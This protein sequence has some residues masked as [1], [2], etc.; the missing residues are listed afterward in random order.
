MTSSVS[1]IPAA[2]IAAAALALPA[3]AGAAQT[4]GSSLDTARGPATSLACQGCSFALDHIDGLQTWT[5]PGVITSFTAKLGAGDLA[6]LRV[7]TREGANRFV[8]V[9]TA[10]AVSG[11]GEVATYPASLRVPANAT[12]GLALQGRLA[13]I[14]GTGRVGIAATSGDGTAA[15]ST[16]ED[17]EPLLSAK[18]ESDYDEDG[19]GDETQDPCVFCSTNTDTGG[20]SSGTSSGGG[21]GTSAG[22]TGADHGGGAGGADTGG[23][24]APKGNPRANENI[25]SRT[26]LTVQDAGSVFT[27]RKPVATAYL[28]NPHNDAVTGTATL[29]VGGKLVAKTR[30]YASTIDALDFRVS[31]AVA[32]L[33]AKGTKG[34]VTAHGLLGRARQGVRRLRRR[35]Q[36]GRHLPLRRQLPRQGP[37]RDQGA[38]RDRRER[39]RLVV[40]VVHQRL[41]EHDARVLPS[42]RRA[43]DHRPGRHGRGPRPRRLRRGAL[44]GAVQEE[45]DDQGLHL[46]VVLPPGRLQQRPHPEHPVP[47]RVQLD[48]PEGVASRRMSGKGILGKITSSVP[49]P[50]PGTLAWKPW[51]AITKLN[52]RLYRATGG[53]IG[54]RMDEAP[55]CVLHHRGA[56]SGQPR[57]TPLLY[58]PDGDDVILVASMGGNPR[59]PAWYHNLKAHPD[60]EVEIGRERRRLT[61]REVEGAERDALWARAEA[62]WPA[63]EAYQGRTTRR[64]PILRLSPRRS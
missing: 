54:G 43:G 41:G 13:A 44:Q 31:R 27:G 20:G 1:M 60:V 23:G 3:V 46:A 48:R 53:R 16:F 39:D 35:L 61:A 29:K 34:T 8:P 15:D 7:Y 51:N 55:V 64:I 37:D 50:R 33:L 17:V 18:V 4:V 36:A 38:P 26:V 6:R 14:E 47:R 10:G 52:V 22:G 24:T 58:L 28:Y 2:A 9:N 40:P 32:K 19:L 63:F 21:G 12:I 59:N 25:R 56:K 5:D 11:T 30:A 57:E 45:R 49:A 62:V 42:H